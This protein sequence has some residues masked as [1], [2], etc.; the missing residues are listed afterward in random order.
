MDSIAPISHVSPLLWTGMI[1]RVRGV[2]AASTFAG[3]RF[4]VSRSM[5]T[6]TGVAPTSTMTSPTEMN[7]R[8]SV[9]TSSPGPIP[10]AIIAMCRAANP[11]LTATPC[12]TPMYAQNS[13]SNRPPSLSF[14]K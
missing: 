5:S 14:S 1:A 3:S 7:V 9:M 4:S 2:M 13:S 6:N 10:A 12:L 8:D 11:E